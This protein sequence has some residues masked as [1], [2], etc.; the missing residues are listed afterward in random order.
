MYLFRSVLPWILLHIYRNNHHWNKRVYTWHHFGTES[1][2]KVTAKEKLKT[3]QK[4]YSLSYMGNVCLNTMAANKDKKRLA[5][6]GQG[7]RQYYRDAQFRP[8][9]W[10]SF[11]VNSVS[12]GHSEQI[13]PLNSPLNRAVRN[14]QVFIRTSS[15]VMTYLPLCRCWSPAFGFYNTMYPFVLYLSNSSNVTVL[16]KNSSVY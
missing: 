8:K 3:L 13:C 10:D 11:Y 6:N 7:G 14:S 1:S 4:N 2:C 12:L 15:T 5:P 16:P 9:Y